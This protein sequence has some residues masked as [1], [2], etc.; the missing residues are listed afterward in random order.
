VVLYGREELGREANGTKVENLTQII[1]YSHH[2]ENNL[3]LE[4]VPLLC[5][6]SLELTGHFR[7]FLPVPFD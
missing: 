3:P 7:N 6:Y 5:S 1:V 2:D 4:R